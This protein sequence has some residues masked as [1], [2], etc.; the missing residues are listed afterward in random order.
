MVFLLEGL[1][2]RN[3]TYIYLVKYNL[4]IKIKYAGSTKFEN[5]DWESHFHGGWEWGFSFSEMTFIT[6]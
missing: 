4:K 1:G 5:K 3:E 2:N 6:L